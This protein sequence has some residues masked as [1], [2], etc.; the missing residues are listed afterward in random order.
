[1]AEVLGITC[2]VVTAI[3]TTLKV[4]KQCKHLI[5]TTHDAPKDLRQIF[6][7]VTSL[8][9]TLE[10]LQFLSVADSDFSDVVRGMN[11]LNGAVHGCHSVMDELAQELDGLQILDTG[12]N[13]VQTATSRK[14]RIKRLIKWVSKESKVF[15]L[16][17]QARAH[18]VYYFSCLAG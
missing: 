15:K 4:I 6:V 12:S 8:N 10:S 18:Q 11:E 16:L 14:Q 1:M 17:E 9:A 7:E 13:N 3:E 5:E 2:G